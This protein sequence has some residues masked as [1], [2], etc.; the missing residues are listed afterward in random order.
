MAYKPDMTNCTGMLAMGE[1]LLVFRGENLTL[2]TH[3]QLTEFTTVELPGLPSPD[4]GLVQ[5][6]DDGVA[7]YNE[8]EKSIV[9][10]GKNL[11]ET[12]RLQLQDD[13]V[14][15]VYLS[16]DWKMAYYCTAEEVCAL[17]MQTGISRLLKEHGGAKKTVT[18]VFLN[19][20]A[21]RCTSMQERD[22]NH[23]SVLIFSCGNESYGGRNIFEMAEHMRRRD[24]SRPVHYE[25]I[26]WDRRYNAT[27]DME[28]QMYTTAAGVAKFI[29][30]HPDKP[31][32]LCEYSHAMGNSCGDLRFYDEI[33]QAHDR[34]MG[35]FI[36]EWCDH[37]LRLIAENG[38]PYLGYG[39]D[40]GDKINLYNFC[41]DGTVSPDR[42][43][44]SN[45]L[46]I[47]LK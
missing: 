16:P 30:E 7:Y 41:M 33:I 42:Q 26:F 14:G 46:E 25:S 34:C 28:S 3:Q 27:S 18:G 9:F 13:V 32:I 47:I 38:E 6:H 35:G 17:D 21:L 15:G 4:S 29:E 44:H 43:P 31:F 19:G 22:K 23:P 5:A 11:R 45:L 39:G 40:F 24:P 2:L 10:L 37:S 1:A 20:R 8:K 12:A 36:W